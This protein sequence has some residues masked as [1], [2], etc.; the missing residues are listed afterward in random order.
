MV[1]R[2]ITCFPDL[3]VLHCRGMKDQDNTEA[4][5]L[6]CRMLKNCLGMGVLIHLHCFNGGP[7]VVKQRLEAFPNIYFGF[8][9]MV[10]TFTGEV[11]RAVWELPEGCLLLETDASYFHIGR[12]WHCTPS[13]I[14]MAAKELARIR[15]GDWRAIL[16][17]TRTNVKRLYGKRGPPILD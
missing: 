4:Y 6:L 7:E 2:V 14:V 16:N 12:N 10:G 1:E 11:T 15:G 8:I 13:V 3:L 5:D 9:N 17:I